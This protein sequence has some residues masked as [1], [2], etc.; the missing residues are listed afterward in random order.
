M[1]IQTTILTALSLGMLAALGSTAN[2]LQ[3]K[4]TELDALPSYALS[5]NNLG[6]APVVNLGYTSVSD[7]SFVYERGTRINIPGVIDGI[8]DKGQLAGYLYLD[9]QVKQSTAF[10][11]TRGKLTTINGGVYGRSSANGINRYGEV[12]GDF[13]VSPTLTHAFSWQNGILTDLGSLGGNSFSYGINNNG[14]IVGA[15]I[16]STGALHAFLYSNGQMQDLGA[17]AGDYSLAQSTNDYGQ[18]AGSINDQ[19]FG[20]H[21]F[22]YANGVMRDLGTLPNKQ[23]SSATGI[24]NSGVIVGSFLLGKDGFVYVN[25]EMHDLATMMTDK[26]WLSMEPNAINDLGQIS[27]LA[28]KAD[29]VIHAVLLTPV[30]K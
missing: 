15:F 17:P 10:I 23:S 25:G 16:T 27:G 9:P 28:V 30:G 4:V 11:Y 24:N 19:V 2:A 3:Y 5:I 29:G 22:L 26:S 8:N 6:Q 18:I 14:Q 20:F 12:T 13:Q 1:N 7:T 21:A